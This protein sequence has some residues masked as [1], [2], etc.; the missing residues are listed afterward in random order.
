M[1]EDFSKQFIKICNNFNQYP[2]N[3]V[4][5]LSG[6]VDSTA[7]LILLKNFIKNCP[8]I[9]IN[10]Y[11][12]I[13]DHGLRSN[14][15]S[16]AKAVKDISQSLGFQTIIKRIT[17]KKPAG[18]IQNWARVERRNLL[19]QSAVSLSA[20]ILLAH[21]YD[22]QAETIFMRLIRGSG[23]EGLLGIKALNFWRGIFIIRPLL[24][25]KKEDL[26]RYVKKN[27][28][29]FFEDSSNFLL[30]YERV[31]IRKILSDMHNSKWPNISK[32]LINLNCLNKKLISIVNPCFLKWCE[33]NVIID[34]SGAARINFY[35]LKILFNRSQSVSIHVLGKILKIIGGKEFSPKRKKT[36]NLLLSILN[37]S[38]KKISLGNV[39]L[40]LNGDF[41]FLIREERNLFFDIKISKNRYY[42]FDGRFLIFSKVSGKII[43]DVNCE[44]NN[45]IQENIFYQYKNQI[46]YTLPI[47]ETLE[48]KHIKPHL[49]IISEDG[50]EKEKIKNGFFGLY[51]INRLLI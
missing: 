27:Q 10:V 43:K 28:I 48:G 32:D 25:F 39:N 15:F 51:L 35:N 44:S 45:I 1:I 42:T 49:C 2:T 33:E 30:K 47:I 41:L 46:N 22:D 38:F 20:H 34:K 24:N 16:E 9:N 26:I 3:F 36:L 11:P 13:I 17:S 4:L 37:V 40:Q 7:L 50:I 12:I 23:I 18:N 6:G 8:D 29:D 14:S 31:K 19:Y 21:H 5:G